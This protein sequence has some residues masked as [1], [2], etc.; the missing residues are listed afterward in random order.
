LWRAAVRKTDGVGVFGVDGKILYAHRFS[1][2]LSRG[3]IP[4]G[5]EVRR[6][7]GNRLCVR[8]GHLEL[9]LEPAVG[10][11]EPDEFQPLC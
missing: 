8:P 4:K 10:K 5:V 3:C 1:W 7:C 2:F 11:I 9:R 6:T